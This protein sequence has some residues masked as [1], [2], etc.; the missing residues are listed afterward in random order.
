VKNTKRTR[1]G[2]ERAVGLGG[3]PGENTKRT[4]FDR[5][6]AAAGWRLADL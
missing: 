5:E 3:T 6:W 4:R 2:R 1:F